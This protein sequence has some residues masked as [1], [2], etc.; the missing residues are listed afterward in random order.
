MIEIL[1]LLR[2]LCHARVFLSVQNSVHVPDSLVPPPL[3]GSK[4]CTERARVGC[5]RTFPRSKHLN[6]SYERAFGAY[7]AN[8][9]IDVATQHNIFAANQDTDIP[10][11]RS[12]R[13][14]GWTCWIISLSGVAETLGGKRVEF[15]HA[16]TPTHSPPDVKT[17]RGTPRS[18]YTL[19]HLCMPLFCLLRGWLFAMGRVQT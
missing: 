11:S 7:A 16:R 19:L 14:C 1:P 12:T 8:Q 13:T 15:L 10:E 18:L 9:E 3:R 4:I 6:L 17:G 2:M 5:P